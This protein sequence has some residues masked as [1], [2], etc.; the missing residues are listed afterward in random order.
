MS[1]LFV[2]CYCRG[3]LENVEKD[4]YFRTSREK[5]GFIWH[6][7]ETHSIRMVCETLEFIFYF[8]ENINL[9]VF[10]VQFFYRSLKFSF[11]LLQL[12]E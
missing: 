2:N 6:Y 5:R 3:T 4:I 12:A 11:P 8:I 9:T 1:V 10:L 7:S